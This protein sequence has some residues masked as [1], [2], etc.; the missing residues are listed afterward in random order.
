MGSMA[1]FNLHT[2]GKLIV[3]FCWRGCFKRGC[4]PIVYFTGSLIAPCPD[5]FSHCNY[6]WQLVPLSSISWWDL[7]I[8]ILRGT[9]GLFS[10]CSSE[11]GAAVGLYWVSSVRFGEMKND[12]FS[13]RRFL[14]WQK[15]SDE[16]P[17]VIQTWYSVQLCLYTWSPKPAT[18]TCR[19]V[20]VQVI[21]VLDLC[22]SRCFCTF[23]IL[24]GTWHIPR[25]W[26]P[27]HLI[28]STKSFQIIFPKVGNV[29]TKWRH[30]H[31]I[32]YSLESYWRLAS[33]PQLRVIFS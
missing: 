23:V 22:S 31:I 3:H 8:S 6:H 12:Q 11:P 1:L 24:A 27:R 29:Q 4:V 5:W 33:M 18:K 2:L 17:P 15:D 20:D 16:G 30:C 28:T 13:R 14:G 19:I 10:I 7:E 25:K 32:T 21:R 26:R 9:T